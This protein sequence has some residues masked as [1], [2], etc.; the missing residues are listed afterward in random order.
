MKRRQFIAHAGRGALAA[1]AFTGPMGAS[2]GTGGETGD[3]RTKRSNFIVVTVDDAGW[4]DFGFH[5]SKIN[6]PTFDRLARGGTQLEQFYVFPTCTPTRAS[7]M[8]GKP[9]T[10]FGLYTAIAAHADPPMPDDAM[11]IANVLGSAGYQTAITGKWHLGNTLD[12]GPNHYGFDH[13]HGFHGPWINQYTHRTQKDKVDWHRNGEYIEQEGHATDLISQEAVDFITDIRDPDRPFYLHVSFNCPHL[14]LQEEDRWVA[15]YEGVFEDESRR[16][17]AAAMS[18]IDAGLARIMD[19][20]AEQGLTEDTLVLFFSDNG[21]ESPGKKGY[22]DPEPDDEYTTHDRTLFA[23]NTPFRGSKYVMYEGGIRVS[24]FAYQPGTIP[25]GESVNDQLIVYDVI[26]TLAGIAGAEVPPE[27]GCEGIDVWQT[28]TG[29]DS[30]PPDRVLYWRLSNLIVVRRGDWKLIHKG[31]TPDEGA[32]ELYNIADDPY[33]TTDLAADRPDM[34][35]ALRAIMRE[36]AA[37]DA[38]DR[39][40]SPSQ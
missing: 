39:Y 13:A 14:P 24:A 37:K 33:E 4:S 31:R 25:A 5:G 27:M 9:P 32:D 16:Y 20:L 6:T 23:D 40:A 1:T 21:G 3:T 8:T 7:L 15:P 10:R 18:H 12:R 2:C 36:Q 29:A 35:A 22:L 34:L 30:V 26:P 28:L 11:T 17:W 38:P 19:A